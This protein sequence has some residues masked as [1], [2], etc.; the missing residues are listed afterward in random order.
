MKKTILA[1]LLAA[2]SLLVNAYA[3][4]VT[5]LPD[6]TLLTMPVLNY[7]GNGPQALSP[8]ITWTSDYNYSVF[9][10]TNGYGFAGHGS[11]SG[12]P[13][14][15][16]NS[17]SNTMTFTF[18][19]AV[20]GFGGF[21][22]W[23]PG[24]GNASIAAYDVNNNLLESAAITFNTNGSLNSGEFHGFRQNS[25]VIKTFTMTGG[26]IGGS[27]FAVVAVPEPETYA[28][29]LAGLA[30]LGLMARRRKA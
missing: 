27:N 15:G 9:G 2:S 19:Q 22:N 28:M 3:V 25:A 6:G 8:N 21:L 13:M 30:G 29:M 4:E 7:F 1:S 26:Y 11:W 5:S 20:V 24:Y 17:G 14:V 10:Y 12:Q 18:A 16:V 23:A